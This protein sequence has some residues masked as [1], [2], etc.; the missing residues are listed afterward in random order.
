MVCNMIEDL[1]IREFEKDDIT[2]L[3]DIILDA[4]NF[5]DPFLNSEMLNIRRD[6][7]SILAASSSRL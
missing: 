6:S 4:E 3:R 2:T 7:I 1:K 5:G